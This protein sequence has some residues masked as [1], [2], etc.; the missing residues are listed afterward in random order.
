[1]LFVT[2][3]GW[4]I[5]ESQFE[6]EVYTYELQQDSGEGGDNQYSNNRIIIGGD[7]H[8]E[9]DDKGDSEAQGVE[10]NAEPE[11]LS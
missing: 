9:T 6:S 2:N 5:Y 4:I 11:N 10:S 1:M 7:Y 3:A 8:G